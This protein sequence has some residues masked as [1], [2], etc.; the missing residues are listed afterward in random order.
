MKELIKLKAF[1][2][3]RREVFV[4]FINGLVE[5]KN[6]TYKIEF[7]K[8][9]NQT[10]PFMVLNDIKPLSEIKKDINKICKYKLELK[11][12]IYSVNGHTYNIIG[13]GVES[14]KAYKDTDIQPKYFRY[15]TTEGQYL[16]NT[17]LEKVE[18]T[19]LIIN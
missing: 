15:N 12:N 19:V 6:K 7:K 4:D 16:L 9:D 8:I 11:N 18:Q 14:I 17:L 1:K 13:I 3:N 2:Q 5:W 10:I